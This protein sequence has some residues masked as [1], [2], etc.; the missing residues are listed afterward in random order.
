MI[1][2]ALIPLAVGFLAAFVAYGRRDWAL[3]SA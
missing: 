3:A 1:A 2:P